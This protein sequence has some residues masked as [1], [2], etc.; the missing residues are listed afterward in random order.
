MYCYLL[1][2]ALLFTFCIAKTFKALQPFKQT[3]QPV[4]ILKALSSARYVSD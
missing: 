3:A 2:I 4:N 1:T